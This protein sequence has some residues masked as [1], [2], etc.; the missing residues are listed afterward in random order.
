[1]SLIA[2]SAD[3]TSEVMLSHSLRDAGSGVYV[4]QVSIEIRG[5]DAA[6]LRSAR[7]GVTTR[8]PMLRTGFLWRELSDSPLQAIYRDAIA[9]FGEEDW[10]GRAVDEARLSAAAAAERFSREQL[11]AFDQPTQLAD[12]FGSVHHAA[13]G[14]QRCYTRLGEDATAVHHGRGGASG[15]I[16]LYAEPFTAAQVELYRDGPQFENTSASGEAQS[17]GN[18]ARTVPRSCRTNFQ[19]IILSVSVRCTQGGRRQCAATIG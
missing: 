6:R 13:S 11:T 16:Y 7:R 3:R 19:V 1:M 10:H 17:S 8:H 15:R 9:P 18:S 12:T 5:P 14:H 4:N 2:V